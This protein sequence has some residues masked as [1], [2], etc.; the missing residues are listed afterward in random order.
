MGDTKL[1]FSRLFLIYLLVHHDVY[2][3]VSKFSLFTS[4]VR[5]E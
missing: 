3:L 1:I 5:V 4:I 2:M